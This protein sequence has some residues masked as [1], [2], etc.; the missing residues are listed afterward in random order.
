MPKVGIKGQTYCNIGSHSAPQWK[1]CKFLRD[2]TLEIS[3]NEVSVKN[4]GSRWEKFL[5]GLDSCPLDIEGDWEPGDPVFDALQAAYWSKQS[6]EF[7]ILDGGIMKSGA[8]GLLAGLMVTKFGR[9]EPLED[10]MSLNV[11]LRLSAD[12]PHEPAWV[13]ATGTGGLE[14]VSAFSEDP[15]NEPV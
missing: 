5:S 7:A 2:V 11:S 1:R 8:Q 14:V 9:G 13:S 12:W 10:V 3:S 6:I 4:K 15:D